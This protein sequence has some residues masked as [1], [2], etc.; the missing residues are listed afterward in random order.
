MKTHNVLNGNIVHGDHI[1]QALGF[2]TANLQTADPLPPDGVYVAR[3]SWRDGDRY[4]MLDIGLRPTVDGKEQRVEIHLLDFHGDLYGEKV[5]IETLHF[6]RKEQK[7]ADTN[8]LRRQL[9]AD[10][11]AT[12]NYLDRNH[13]KNEE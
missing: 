7:F 8:A 2:P 9:D 3:M 6:L 10:L 12:R 5:Q 4:G 11:E 1:G 13:L